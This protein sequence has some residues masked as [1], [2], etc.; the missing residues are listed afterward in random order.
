MGGDELDL[1]PAYEIG[2]HQHHVAAMT[3]GLAQRLA[4]ALPGPS[5][6]PGRG[7]G[8]KGERERDRDG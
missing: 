7:T 1:Q 3:G 5:G 8:P 4:E 2:A 6:K